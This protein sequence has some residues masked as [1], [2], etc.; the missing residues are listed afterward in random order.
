MGK[1]ADRETVEEYIDGLKSTFLY[2]RELGHNWRPYTAQVSET[3]DHY[4]RVLRCTRCRTERW[5]LISRRGAI[6]SSHYHYVEGYQS[7]GLGRIVGEARDALR[8]AS[9]TREVRDN[10]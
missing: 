5:Q 4:D 1:Y 3:A 8:V 2:C 10:G 7:K 6:V 9:I